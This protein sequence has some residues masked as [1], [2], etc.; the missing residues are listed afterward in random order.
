MSGLPLQEAPTQ[1]KMYKS[2]KR[3]AY[4]EYLQKTSIVLPLPPL[5]YRP[6]PL[7]LKRSVLLDF[8]FYQY[9]PSEDEEQAREIDQNK[10]RGS[11]NEDQGDAV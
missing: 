11:G 5:L 7:W 1:K 4:Q 2:D 10:S 3:E 6:L 9:K 8:P